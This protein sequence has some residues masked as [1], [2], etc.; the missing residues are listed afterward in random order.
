MTT[1][2]RYGLVLRLSKKGLGSEIP[3]VEMMILCIATEPS[4]SG[5][6]RMHAQLHAA[7]SVAYGWRVADLPSPGTGLHKLT[8]KCKEAAAPQARQPAKV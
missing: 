1:L 2:F 5:P 6:A 3:Y 4:S 7:R 8:C